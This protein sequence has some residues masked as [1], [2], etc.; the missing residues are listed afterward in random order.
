MIPATNDE[1]SIPSKIITIME[2][3]GLEVIRIAELI[4]IDA[5]SVPINNHKAELEILLLFKNQGKMPA[6]TPPTPT[7]KIIVNNLLNAI[8]AIVPV[9]IIKIHKIHSR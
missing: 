4:K 1:V 9:S 8:P 2:I 3:L 7:P 5:I 6:V